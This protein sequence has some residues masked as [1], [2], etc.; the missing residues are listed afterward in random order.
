MTFPEPSACSSVALSWLFSMGTGTCSSANQ[1][2]R[3]RA[4]NSCGRLRMNWPD[5]SIRN[6]R[7]GKWNEMN[8]RRNCDCLSPIR[9]RIRPK[10][11]RKW[12]RQ[13]SGAGQTGLPIAPFAL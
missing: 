4:S 7:Y 5:L 1:L 12:M 2:R 3:C 9:N 8:R 10:A 13:L 6:A 11:T